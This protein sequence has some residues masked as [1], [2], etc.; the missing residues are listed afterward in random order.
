MLLEFYHQAYDRI[1]RHIPAKR[2][3]VIIEAHPHFRLGE[4]HGKLQTLGCEN[5]ITDIHPYQ[6]FY[7]VYNRLYLHEHLALP[8]GQT[9]PRLKE[10]MQA[11]PLI[12]GEWSLAIG[13]MQKSF[14]ELPKQHRDLALR[15]FAA[16]Q[17]ALFE[18]TDGWFFWSYKTESSNVWSL[19]ECV[20]QSWFPPT[21]I[22]A[23]P[24][25][26]DS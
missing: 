14:V 25:G 6:S 7:E 10:A 23:E 20:A 2:A 22:A 24:A 1:R 13:Q 21:L 11:G 3:P 26:K 16:A 4:I 17:L 5:V 18:Y 9:Y 15:A 19:R 8:M 12:I